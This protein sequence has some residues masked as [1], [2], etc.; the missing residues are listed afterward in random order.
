MTTPPRTTMARLV[1]VLLAGLVLA[2]SVAGCAGTGSRPGSL[3]VTTGG[4]PSGTDPSGAPAPSAGT[5]VAPT[6]SCVS[7]TLA[8][9]EADQG[10][11]FCVHAGTAVRVVLHGSTAS[12]WRPVRLTGTALR[13]AP[14]G[15]GT[16]P[17]G[18]TA[19]FFVAAAPGE[20]GLTS[21]RPACPSPSSGGIA[22]LALVGFTVTIHVR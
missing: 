17:V 9:T 7:G 6:G 14:S 20:A 12:M 10:R 5:P 18:V 8:L 4:R 1:P 19:A 2:G 3:Q 16:V 11:A 15:R 22:C 13:P 21:F